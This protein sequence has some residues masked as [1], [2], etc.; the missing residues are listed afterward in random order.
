MTPFPMAE[1]EGATRINDTMWL[2][3]TFRPDTTNPTWWHWC[4]VTDR[5]QAAGTGLHTVVS[6]DPWHLEASL[7][8]SWCCGLHGFIREG[9]W[10]GV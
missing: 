9:R 3:P 4:L 2:T 8:A 7:L 1:V 6:R 10:I 5:W